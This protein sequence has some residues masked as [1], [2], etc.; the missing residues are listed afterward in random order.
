MIF[1]GSKFGFV[2]LVCM[3]VASFLE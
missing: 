3:G 1:I 2:R